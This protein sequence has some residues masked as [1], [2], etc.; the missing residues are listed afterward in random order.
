MIRGKNFVIYWAGKGYNATI[1][2]AKMES[3]FGPSAPSYSW[4]TKWLRGLKR[5]EDICEPGEGSGRP[6][7][8]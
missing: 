2:S 3:Y 8:H 4:V 6:K 7:I 5:L 1:L